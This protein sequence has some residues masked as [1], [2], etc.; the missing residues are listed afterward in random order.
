MSL[1]IWSGRAG[2]IEAALLGLHQGNSRIDA[3][4][5]TKQ[6]E[7]LYRRQITGY[8]VWATEAEIHHQGGIFIVWRWEE[9]WSLIL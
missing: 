4:L 9:G 7:M 2:G 1:N 8:Y 3:L 6:L 5:E